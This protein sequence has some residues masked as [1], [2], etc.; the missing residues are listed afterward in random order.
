MQPSVL[1]AGFVT[2]GLFPIQACRI[3][4]M[5]LEADFFPKEKFKGQFLFGHTEVTFLWSALIKGGLH[6]SSGSPVALL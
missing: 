2:S 5:T 1:G 4:T 6:V 3:D